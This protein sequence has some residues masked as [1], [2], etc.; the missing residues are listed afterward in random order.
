M[1]LRNDEMMLYIVQ[2]SFR[3]TKTPAE[4]VKL[5]EKR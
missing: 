1:L 4:N 2:K 3:M 5:K